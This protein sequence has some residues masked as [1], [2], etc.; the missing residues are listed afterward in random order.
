MVCPVF[1]GDY[2]EDVL[3]NTLIERL[4]ALTAPSREVDLLIMRHAENIGGDR[5]N[6]LPYTAS[7]DAA[8]TLVPEK[9]AF[10][11]G[12]GTSEPS[13]ESWAWCGPDEGPYAWGATP[14]IAL[15]IAAIKAREAT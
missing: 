8:M 15:C 13:V 6:A 7:I 10:G 14:A 11:C 4:E 1:D 2:R 3:M 9:Y 5:E 12:K